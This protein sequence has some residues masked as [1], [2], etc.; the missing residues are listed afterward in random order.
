[1]GFYKAFP[2]FSESTVLR[3][4]MIDTYSKISYNSTYIKEI[5]AMPVSTLISTKMPLIKGEWVLY[6]YGGAIPWRVVFFMGNTKHPDDV[7]PKNFSDSLELFDSLF[8]EELQSETD[9]EGP[10]KSPGDQRRTAPEKVPDEQIEEFPGDSP[11]RQSEE[12]TS[13]PVAKPKTA[14]KTTPPPI[15]KPSA[16]S[17]KSAP[18]PQPSSTKKNDTLL[19]TLSLKM[20]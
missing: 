9:T 19:S 12:G 3:K 11:K 20:A 4:F 7:K 5:P 15:A 18:K 17:R 13:R 1:M 10:P 14:P 8:Q 2:W 16:A 6:F